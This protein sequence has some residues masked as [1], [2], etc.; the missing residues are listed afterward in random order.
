MGSGL[1]T[2]QVISRHEQLQ[3]E[4]QWE[5]HIRHIFGVPHLLVVVKVFADLLEHET[6]AVRLASIEL[7]SFHHALDVLEAT[8]IRL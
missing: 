5:L 6:A 1:H 2:I 4:L 8:S 3:T 7:S